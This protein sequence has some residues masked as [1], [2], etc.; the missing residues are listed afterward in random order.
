MPLRFLELSEGSKR[1]SRHERL[2]GATSGIGQHER[3][4]VACAFG[5]TEHLL[6]EAEF[7]RGI[8]ARSLRGRRFQHRLRIGV[9][10]ALDQ[11]P[12]AETGDGGVVRVELRERA[13][14]LVKT[15]FDQRAGRLLQR[16][17]TSAALRETA[18]GA[19]QDDGRDKNEQ[20][21]GRDGGRWP[22]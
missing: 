1:A 19:Q 7:E 22:Q 9:L 10:A 4:K 20:R 11:R 15:A 6:Q 3:S 2:G 5:P 8:A 13:V 17:R 14:D 12:A 16:R 21:E 18:G